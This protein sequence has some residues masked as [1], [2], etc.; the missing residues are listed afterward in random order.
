LQIKNCVEYINA[1][2]I[3][4]RHHG[5]FALGFSSNKMEIIYVSNLNIMFHTN[6]ET[7]SSKASHP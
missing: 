6:E 1:T 2:V 4:I 3:L 7:L 5:N